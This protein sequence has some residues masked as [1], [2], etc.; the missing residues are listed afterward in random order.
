L[1]TICNMYKHV[2]SL[3]SHRAEFNNIRNHILNNVILSSTLRTSIQD[4]RD[5]S[6]WMQGGALSLQCIEAELNNGIQD[7]ESILNWIVGETSFKKISDVE[8]TSF[9][10]QGPLY[11]DYNKVKDLFVEYFTDFPNTDIYEY[12]TYNFQPLLL[13]NSG[14]ILSDLT[15]AKVL[16]LRNQLLDI[17]N[18]LRSVGAI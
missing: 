9:M 8:F 18:H 10:T 6:C 13:G 1:R 3:F 12:I 5:G 2:N 15:N 7:T 16:T 14:N 4:M 17:Y 11:P